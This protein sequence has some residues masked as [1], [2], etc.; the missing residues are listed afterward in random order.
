MNVLDVALLHTQPLATMELT[1]G[2]LPDRSLVL[3]PVGPA[4]LPEASGGGG[5]LS[6]DGP[7]VLCIPRKCRHTGT[8][9]K[10]RYLAKPSGPGFHENRFLLRIVV[11]SGLRNCHSRKK[12][13]ETLPENKHCRRKCQG[14]ECGAG[15]RLRM[16]SG[17]VLGQPGPGAC[18]FGPV[19]ALTIFQV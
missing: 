4:D 1:A 10:K 6:V 18:G 14:R 17:G 19:A 15:G 16:T 12:Q 11:C 13:V 3:A 8:T 7:P 5:Y 9:S 2:H